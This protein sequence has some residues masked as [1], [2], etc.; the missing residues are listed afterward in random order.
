MLDGKEL[1]FDSCLRVCCRCVA[2]KVWQVKHADLRPSKLRTK[3]E[4]I[5]TVASQFRV[6]RNVV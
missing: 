4:I 2:G 3:S 1:L 5:Q 6:K